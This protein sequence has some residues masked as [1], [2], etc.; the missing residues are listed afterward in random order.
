MK[1]DKTKEMEM[2]KKDSIDEKST[3][4]IKK[5]EMCGTCIHFRA[6]VNYCPGP[7]DGKCLRHK[8]EE[9]YMPVNASKN[10]CDQWEE[11]P[12]DK[13]EVENG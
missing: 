5:L 3:G 9:G 8:D 4:V 10:T 6:N 12:D 13:K 2:E 1:E 7:N 11:M